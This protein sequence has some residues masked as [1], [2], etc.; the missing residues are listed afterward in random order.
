MEDIIRMRTANV[1]VDMNGVIYFCKI[2]VTGEYFCDKWTN[3]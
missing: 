3:T 2:L 1:N